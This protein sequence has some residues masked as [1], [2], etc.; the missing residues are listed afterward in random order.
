[1]RNTIDLTKWYLAGLIFSLGLAPVALVFTSQRF[2]SEDAG[3]SVLMA[4]EDPWAAPIRFC[5]SLII[6]S[7]SLALCLNLF[8]SA[9][10]PPVAIVL[11]LCSILYM[12]APAVS[13]MLSGKYV[14]FYFF[15]S[16]L[17]LTAALL[18]HD[19]YYKSLVSFGR[20]VCLIL[21]W[22]SLLLAVIWPDFAVEI[23]ALRLYGVAEHANELAIAPILYFAL[24]GF[25]RRRWSTLRVIN[26]VAAL[27]VAAFAYSKTSLSAAAFAA[28]LAW[29]LNR[30]GFAK[31]VALTALGGLG[32]AAVF[33]VV[34]FLPLLLPP[35]TTEQ[36]LTFT[37]RNVIWDYV[38]R[39]WENE[40][41]F[42]YGPLLLSDETRIQLLLENGFTVPHAHNQF[43]QT[44]GM[45]G[46]FGLSSLLLYLIA[47]AVMIIRYGRRSQNVLT[48][49][50]VYLLIRCMTEVPLQIYPLG[51]DYFFHFFFF[52]LCVLFSKTKEISPPIRSSKDPAWEGASALSGVNSD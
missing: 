14:A 39:L 18:L 37:G 17:I 7:F 49:L 22:A 24:E 11:W 19:Q 10:T 25:D 21:I 46:L 41:L 52:S 26:T 50:F 1:M 43:L 44:L 29:S 51:L 33:T 48:F 36:L 6:G 23:P 28:A 30:T 20:T 16:P 27:V 8:G 15:L 4:I 47:L 13:G 34:A 9:R 38:I 5:S 45:S 2:F 3:F 35:S 42:G 12:M 32:V 40:T 31:Y